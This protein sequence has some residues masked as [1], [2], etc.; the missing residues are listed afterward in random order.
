M[1]AVDTNVL[2]R[3]IAQDD[4]KQ[5]ASARAFVAQGVW[6]SVLALAEAIWVL[7]SGYQ[8]GD[9]ELA[10]A[11]QMLLESQNLVVQDHDTVQSALELYRDKP[12]LGF[13]D[14]LMVQLAHDAGHVP[15]GTFDRKLAR[16]HGAEHI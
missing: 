12:A 8:F 6:V 16:V 7:E 13:T 15:L 3:L 2:V 14:C 11:I 10:G 9:P 1:R 4:A 5:L